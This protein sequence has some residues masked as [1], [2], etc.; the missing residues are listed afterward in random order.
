M[1][2]LRIVD[3]RASYAADFK[4]LNVEWITEQWDLDDS[5]ARLL[6]DPDRYVLARGG[7]I[8]IALFDDQPAGT[9]ALIPCDEDTLELAKMAVA[10][11][12]RGL[13]IGYALG[14]AALARARE[15]G[16]KRV[17]LKSDSSL[18]PALSLYRKLGFSET[19][20]GVEH[21]RCNVQMEKS[22]GK[23]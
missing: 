18:G 17:Y 21:H 14:E 2:A 19:N 22:L 10:P 15:R 5:D 11:A 9:V 8:L 16:A 13:G 3:Y 4:R 1:N 6:D 23:T 12:F 20:A 7:D